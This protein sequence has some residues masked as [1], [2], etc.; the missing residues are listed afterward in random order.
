MIVLFAIIVLSLCSTL[1]NVR[2]LDATELG[3]VQSAALGG[4]MLKPRLDALH[5]LC[6]QL[7]SPPDK[8]LKASKNAPLRNCTYVWARASVLA[9]TTNEPIVQSLDFLI[10][11]DDDSLAHDAHYHSTMRLCAADCTLKP[12]AHATIAPGHTITGRR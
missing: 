1:T 10:A 9:V 12:S 3:D 5:V 8:T 6:S 2:V 4:L 11:C 7:A